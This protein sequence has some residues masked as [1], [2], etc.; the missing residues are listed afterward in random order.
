MWVIFL[1]SAI[2]VS[3]I[4]S[5]FP[6]NK[7]EDSNLIPNV[8]FLQCTFWPRPI[9]QACVWKFPICKLSAQ[10][11]ATL[12]KIC[13]HARTKSRSDSE[14]WPFPRRMPKGSASPIKTSH[15]SLDKTQSTHLYHFYSH[16]V[17][18]EFSNSFNNSLPSLS[19]EYQS[20]S[21]F[22]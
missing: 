8:F 16:V 15:P 22:F 11:C 14:R 19:P 21:V 2:S 7:Q 6:G 10:A 20:L 4:L 3:C 18:T 9:F 1:P 12:A 17:R 5:P 13:L